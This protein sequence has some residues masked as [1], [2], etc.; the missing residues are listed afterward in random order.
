[1]AGKNKTERGFRFTWDGQ[2]LSGDLI[3]G[4]VNGGGITLDEVE[5]TGVS[6]AV[7]N[8]LGGHGNSP[9]SAQFHLNDT[10]NRAFNVLKDDG[11]VAATLLMEFGSSGAAPIQGDPTWSGT[12]VFLG[13]SVA[14]NAG[15]M[16]MTA[17]W[18][19]SGATAPAWGTK[20]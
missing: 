2:D 5:M 19:P 17:N 18:R 15:R 16:V 7:K 12:Y 13:F 4:S 3:P 8:F 9:V 10:S 11:G 6:E 1:M 20:A 14:P